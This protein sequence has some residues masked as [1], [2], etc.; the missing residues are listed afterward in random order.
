ML[1]MTGPFLLGGTVSRIIG[2][3][4]QAMILQAGMVCGGRTES[5]I[6]FSIG[7]TMLSDVISLERTS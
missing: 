7:P 2:W 1:F 6:D 5:P 4:N 3:G